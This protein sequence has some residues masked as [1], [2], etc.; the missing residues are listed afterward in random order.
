MAEEVWKR[1]G[2][3]DGGPKVGGSN[4]FFFFAPGEIGS[5]ADSLLSPPQ[6][7]ASWEMELSVKLESLLSLQL[8]PT[9]SALVR[10]LFFH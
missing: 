10:S 7:R 8:Q 5:D 2:L 1:L 4:S 3:G 6:Q 9:A